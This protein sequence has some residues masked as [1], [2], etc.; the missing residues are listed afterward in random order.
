MEKQMTIKI[1]LLIA[2]MC[3]VSMLMAEQNL[4]LGVMVGLNA[5]K[6]AVTG[7]TDWDPEFLDYKTKFD[8]VMGPFLQYNIG[9]RLSIRP[10]ILYSRKGAFHEFESQV[11]IGGTQI[12][13][14]INKANWNLSY[15]QI[16]ILAQYQIIDNLNVFLGPSLG[17]LLSSKEKWEFQGTYLGNSYST[18]GEDDMKDYTKGTDISVIIGCEFNVKKVLFDLRYDHGLTILGEGED[19]KFY[20]RTI[21][22]LMGYQ[23]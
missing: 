20:N 16:P 19:N 7:D 23:F 3:A 13:N 2:L 9:K 6:V 10:E 1:V 14:G 12:Y 4:K 22:F 15:L 5:S 17:K 21:T 18:S 11:T 8:F